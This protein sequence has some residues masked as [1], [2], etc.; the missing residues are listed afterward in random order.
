MLNVGDATLTF[1]GDTTQLDQ[2]FARIPAQAEASMAA[3]ASSVGQVGTAT[4]ALNFEL[5]AT[6]SNVPFCGEAIKDAMDKGAESTRGMGRELKTTEQMF[7]IHLP[8]GVSHFLAELPGVSTAITAA[9]SASVVFF[10]LE[11]LVQVTEKLSNF[12]GS[13]FIYTQA[14]KDAETSGAAYNKVM[15]DIATATQKANATLSEYGMTTVQ[16][17]NVAI[18]ALSTRY[19]ANAFAMTANAVKTAQLS[20]EQKGLGARINEVTGGVYNTLNGW[21]NWT[22]GVDKNTG[23]LTDNREAIKASND[24]RAKGIML[25]AE[26]DREL[27]VLELQL[28]D[29]EDAARQ[30][31]LQKQNA[32][33]QASISGAQTV[34]TALL[35][36]QKAHA[37]ATVAADD[38]S[39][40][41]R[42]L[43]G[44]AYENASYQL[45]VTG[46]AR[47]R[48]AEVQFENETYQLELANL[49]NR[50]A[51][52]KTLGA[53]GI[54]AAAATYVQIEQLT[55][56]H[57]LQLSTE[58][59]TF[60][61]ETK[62]IETK[63]AA[64]TVQGYADMMA[65]VHSIV[66]AGVQT[67]SSDATWSP[68]EKEAIKSA[69]AIEK[70]FETLGVTP[71]AQL[72]K[73]LK[74]AGDAYTTL[75]KSG[76]ASSHDLAQANLSVLQSQLALDKALGNTTAAKATQKAID[77]LTK[78]LQKF[79]G[80]TPKTQSLWDKF[81]A[82][83]EKKAKD[84]GTVSQQ[85]GQLVAQ[86]AE[87]M[88][89]AFESAIASAILSES[90]FGAALK[91]AT[92]EVL[93]Q[94]AAQA[95]VKAMFY[96]AE[97]IV[98]AVTGD[99]AE[100]AG[101]FAAAAEMALV[102]GAAGATARAIGGGAASSSSSTAST[103]GTVTPSTST[104]AAGVGPAT[105]NVPKLFSGAIVTQPTLAMVGD[106]EGGGSR[107]EGVFPL[108]D[109]RAKQ[110]LMDA[111][112]ISGGGDTIHNYN[113]QGM[114]STTDL[115]RLTRVISRG[116]NTGRVRISVTNSNRVTRR[117]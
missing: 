70:A 33:N 86:T 73:A 112:G 17:T 26:M 80:E 12:I 25:Q 81:V 27:I 15:L 3:A 34:A 44:L 115:T 71:V 37:E 5:D 47:K 35:S 82:D 31:T 77:D 2:V 64:A 83:Y 91:K 4:S 28:R 114:I 78:S 65:R 41:K 51:V 95:A 61:A 89:K 59:A 69:T 60:S 54:A 32:F 40:A 68:V 24:E 49:Q 63:R 56:S 108:G 30:Q 14:M 42:L 62:A 113:I 19:T 93:A 117:T 20:E 96:T 107:A 7:G 18:E 16:K 72:Q 79:E 76:V 43:I 92:A 67:I 102:A 100:A 10:L 66:K 13:T 97:G 11:A 39:G 50:L 87:K 105:V 111:F 36:L 57:H 101:Y 55:K 29:E 85:M 106:R 38:E 8:L 52:E 74:V 46:R 23:A 58:D 103:T 109:P 1:L 98:A 53:T 90:S 116:A 6:A 94:L 110:A 88:Q 48:A 45:A 104:A 21:M 75:A 99:E 84:M 9:F 22:V